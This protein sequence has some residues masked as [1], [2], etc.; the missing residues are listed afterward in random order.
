MSSNNETQVVSDFNELNISDK[1]S[2]SANI[3]HDNC[4][5]PANNKFGDSIYNAIRHRY[6]GCPSFLEWVPFDRFKDMK[7][8]GEGGFA[9]VY[10]ATW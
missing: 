7:Q 9:K 10:S 3:N 6:P 5:D 1:N 2:I 4:Y 8:I